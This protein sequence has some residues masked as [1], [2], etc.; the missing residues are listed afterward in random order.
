MSELGASRSRTFATAVRI[1][2][3]KTSAIGGGGFSFNAIGAA[4]G[5]AVRI[6]VPGAS[7]TIPSFM[8]KASNGGP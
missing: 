5:G 1:I 6:E 4:W 2:E 7:V 3:S 8:I